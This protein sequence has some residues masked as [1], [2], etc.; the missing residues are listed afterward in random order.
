MENSTRIP[1]KRVLLLGHTGFLGKAIYRVFQRDGLLVRGYGSA[2]LDLRRFE[3]LK[4]LDDQIDADTVLILASALTPDKGAT[5]EALQDNFLMYINVGRYL[6]TQAVGAC[7]YI[8]SDAV[9]PFRGNPVTEDTPVEPASMYGLAKY[10]GERILARQAEVRGWPLLN[11]RLTALYGPGDPH[12]SYGPNSFMRSLLKEKAVRLFGKGE[13]QRDHL[14][15]EDAARLVYQLVAAK[16]RGTY[17]LATGHSQSFSDVV[18]VL[19]QVV[20]DSFEVVSAPRKAPVT[21]RHF[22][23]TKLFLHVPWFHFRS[24]EEGLAGYYRFSVQGS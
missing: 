14:H 12:G 21:H 4:A 19:R 20:P 2:E 1:Y 11:L 18:E 5:L 24:I 3:M 16:A 22:D 9:Y 17:N 23:V 10:S 7:V 15:V 13:E 8:S 6:E